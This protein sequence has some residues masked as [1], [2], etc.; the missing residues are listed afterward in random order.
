MPSQ[1]TS[2]I[3]RIRGLNESSNASSCSVTPLTSLK[4]QREQTFCKSTLNHHHTTR[5]GNSSTRMPLHDFLDHQSLNQKTAVNSSNFNLETN[6][7]SGVLVVKPHQRATLIRPFSFET[8][9]NSVTSSGNQP[10]NENRLNYRCAL[11][12]LPMPPGPKNAG[13]DSVNY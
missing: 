7:I 9:T 6:Q 4:R 11:T 12:S 13:D 8:S 2:A 5:H 3:M 10:A 1:L